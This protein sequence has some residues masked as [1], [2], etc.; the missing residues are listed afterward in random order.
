MRSVLLLALVALVTLAGCGGEPS[1]RGKSLSEWDTIL[2]RS[3]DPAE[4]KQCATAIQ[5]LGPA[6][7]PLAWELVRLLSDRKAFGH[8]RSMTDQQVAD[9][10]Q[11]FKPALRAIGASAGPV[12]IQAVEN[13]RPISVDVLQGLHPDALATVASGMGHTEVRVRRELAGLWGGLGA[14]GRTGAEALVNAM[15]DTD[16]TVRA[17]ATRSLGPIDAP[18]DLAVPALLAALTDQQTLVRFTACESLAGYR[19][20]ADRWLPALGNALADPEESVRAAA[21]KT[22]GQCT[23]QKPQVMAVLLPIL[24]G[25]NPVARN[26][27]MQAVIALDRVRDLPSPTLLSF[28]SAEPFGPVVA[29]TLLETDPRALLFVPGLVGRLTGSIDADTRLRQDVLLKLG[30]RAVPVLIKMLQ[31]QEGDPAEAEVVRY[32]ATMALS[33]LGKPAQPALGILSKM[34]DTES[35]EG[36][37][38]AAAKALKQIHAASR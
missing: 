28:L 38:V 10:F 1:V 19:S 7:Q 16:D 14:N 17:A 32:E 36:L 35:S 18:A 30:D 37:R 9:I 6:A 20:V 5:E 21:V 4:L 29:A 8:Y 12:V 25:T 24:Q 13:K 3:H 26:Y 31:Y 34:A 33:A 15:A 22:F 2:K 27:G 11:V 23:D